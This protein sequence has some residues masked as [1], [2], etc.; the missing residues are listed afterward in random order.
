MIVAQPNN[1][2]SESP[3]PTGRKCQTQLEL[4]ACPNCKTSLADGRCGGCGESFDWTLDILDLRWPRAEFDEREKNF[5]NQLVDNFDTSTF[6]EMSEMVRRYHFSDYSEELLEGLKSRANDPGQLGR[7]MLE[8]FSSRS[9]SYFAPSEGHVALDVGCGYGTATLTLAKQFDHVIAL[10]PYLPVLLLCKKFLQEQGVRNVLL[11]QANAQSIPLHDR[12]VDYTIAQNVIEH[13]FDVSPA[14]VEV[15]RTLAEHGRFCADS[16][17]RYDLL[18]PEP[19]VRIRWVGM[20]PRFLQS[21]YVRKRLGVSY[22]DAHARLLSLRELTQSTN[23]AFGDTGIIVLPLVS[24]YGQ[25]SKFDKWIERI[26]KVPVLR[27]L[28]LAIFPSHLLLA[29]VETPDDR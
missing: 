3:Q 14:L 10:D 5:V 9:S 7:K 26:D 6:A 25:S 23:D 11:I 17:N 22:E 4:L 20:F 8:M 13:L 19:H 18:F 12:C 27:H 1:N 16:R 24:A 2:E 29:Q 28:V 15:E 21:W